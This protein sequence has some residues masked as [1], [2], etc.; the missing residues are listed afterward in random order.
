M[1]RL[2]AIAPGLGSSAWVLMDTDTRRPLFAGIDTNG[3]IRGLF[4][5]L[6]PSDQVV[7]TYR[8]GDRLWAGRFIELT[9]AAGIHPNRLDLTI[10]RALLG[11]TAPI[12]ATLRQALIDRFAPGVPNDGKGTNAH[13]GWFHGFAGDMWAA[14]ALG[15]AWLDIAD[16]R[17]ATE[18][19]RS[20]PRSAPT[21]AD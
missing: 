20:A 2:L 8:D 14:Y 6:V 9:I 21:P 4:D 15:V 19:G 17:H 1:S 10:A 5:K 3:E 12:G 7:L 11:D 18:Q 16:R 13:P